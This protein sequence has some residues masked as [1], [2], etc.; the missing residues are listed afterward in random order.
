[1][2]GE[3]SR[4]EEGDEDWYRA[5]VQRAEDGD[6]DE[7]GAGEEADDADVEVG[8]GGGEGPPVGEPAAREGADQAA[9]DY[10]HAG[11][12][13]GPPRSQFEAPLEDG[14]QPEGVGREDEE[15]KGLGDDRRPQGGDS[16]EV[17]ELAKAGVGGPGDGRAS[18]LGGAAQRF[19][20]PEG[21]D[22]EEEAR[23][24]REEEGG[25]PT[26]LLSDEAAPGR[27]ERDTERASGPPDRSHAAALILG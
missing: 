5:D 19:P 10:D 25:P 27:A 18:C 16:H 22:G 12:Q 11:Q 24:G 23:N 14:R 26:E 7:D 3:H 4:R 6:G 9:D 1:G 8:L 2:G 13:S 20:H 17:D 15:E 21:E